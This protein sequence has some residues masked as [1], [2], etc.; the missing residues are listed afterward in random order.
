MAENKFKNNQGKP[1]FDLEAH[2]MMLNEME[3]YHD[4]IVPPDV[5]PDWEM[6]ID[7][8]NFIE[9]NQANGPPIAEL[10]YDAHLTG[11]SYEV[12]LEGY[13][14]IIQER[15]FRKESLIIDASYSSL[16]EGEKNLAYNDY[17][18]FPKI[19]W[20]VVSNYGAGY[21]EPKARFYSEPEGPGHAIN[22]HS[23]LNET[24]N[25]DDGWLSGI[26]P[27]WE[28][29]G[30]FVLN[31]AGN[32]LGVITGSA[33]LGLPEPTMATKIVGGVVLGKSLAG[34]GLNWHNLTTAFT[35]DTSEYDAPSTAMRAA[36]TVIAPGNDKALLAADSVD[37]GFDFLTGR[38]RIH[39]NFLVP[40]I[41]KSVDLVDRYFMNPG[42]VKALQYLQ[43]GSIIE[44]DSVV[45]R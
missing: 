32:G 2:N 23:G 31:L 24:K 25:I 41:T 35:Q 34:W 6:Y 11:L 45:S 12:P 42:A 44:E 10:S 20:S 22:E 4:P 18:M 19:D 15:F 21:G 17:G 8:E 36:A 5:D 9:K 7:T 13:E 43:Q 33:M 28:Q 38:P 30:K 1:H 40:S 16:E 26:D 39:S 29:V 14:G 27:R 3:F 37:L